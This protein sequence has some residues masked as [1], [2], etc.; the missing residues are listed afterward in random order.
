M[1]GQETS[2]NK[3]WS[4]RINAS[5][6]RELLLPTTPGMDPQMGGHTT[7]HVQMTRLS[8]TC[9]NRMPRG[10]ARWTLP[11]TSK[12]ASPTVLPGIHSGEACKWAASQ[13]VKNEIRINRNSGHQIAPCIAVNRIR[14]DTF[15]ANQRIGQDHLRAVALI[16][17]SCMERSIIQSSGFAGLELPC[18]GLH[19]IDPRAQSEEVATGR[20]VALYLGG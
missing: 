17:H 10:T 1:C 19:G 18:R 3:V 12:T 16:L 5:S 4:S 8:Y 20:N 13:L 9:Q 15:A 14:I 11:T 6:G 2:V 7:L